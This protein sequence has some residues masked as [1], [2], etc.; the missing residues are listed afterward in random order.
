[1]LKNLLITL[2]IIVVALLAVNNTVKHYNEEFGVAGVTPS[3]FEMRTPAKQNPGQASI[4][5]QTQQAQKRK[6]EPDFYKNPNSHGN[7]NRNR[8][9]DNMRQNFDKSKQGN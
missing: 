7:Y 1:M 9:K 3:Q 4:D 6:I 5:Y 2:G 8:H